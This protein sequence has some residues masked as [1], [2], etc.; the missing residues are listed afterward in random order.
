[1]SSL[2]IES[3]IF[4]QPEIVRSS[5]AN[6]AVFRMVIQ[7]A[8]EV[9]QNNRLYPLDV[10]KEGMKKIETKIK[11]RS[12]FCEL[13][14]PL[15]HPDSEINLV[16]QTQALLK[17]VSHIIIDY[18][19]RGNLLYAEME[20]LNTPN[21]RTLLG[22]LSDKCAIGMSLRGLGDLTKKDDFNVATSLFIISYDA[23]SQ[24]SHQ[25]AVVNI[26]E[27]KFVESVK[28]LR[29]DRDLRTHRKR[30]TLESICER[31]G[32]ICINNDLCYLPEFFDQLIERKIIEILKREI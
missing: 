17:E 20:T 32:L 11:T 23:V 9:N 27:V 10:L 26:D 18:E 8:N 14:H 25:S 31:D 19:F 7:S 30:I 5:Y 4:Q 24:P 21:G 1:M 3:P 2:I 28:L 12:M 22:L 13:D 29:E 15:P 6:K 16:R